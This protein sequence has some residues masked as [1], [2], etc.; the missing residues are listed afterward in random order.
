M[1]ASARRRGLWTALLAVL[2][3]AGAGAVYAE[4]GLY[5]FNVLLLRGGSFWDAVPPDSPRLSPSMRLA[6]RDPPPAGQPGPLAWRTLAGTLKVEDE[7]GTRPLAWRW[8]RHG[9]PALP[10]VLAVVRR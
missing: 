3:A 10:V 8:G 2:I 1:T 9:R 4:A 5:G 6:L 7:G